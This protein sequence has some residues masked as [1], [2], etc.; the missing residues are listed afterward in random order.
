MKAIVIKKHGEISYKEVSLRAPKEGEVV[1]K[2]KASG[3]C[4]TDYKRIFEGKSYFYPIILGH[5]FSGIIYDKGSKVKNFKINDKVVVAPLI[6][7]RKCSYCREGNYSL[8]E[9]YNYIGSR[10]SG[11]YAEYVIVPQSNVLKISD[12]LDFEIAAFIE[13]TAIAIHGLL[14]VMKLGYSVLV[15]GAGTIGLISAQIAYRMGA[16]K[17]YIADIKMEPLNIAKN[18]GLD[19]VL[20]DDNDEERL[21]ELKRK[22]IDVV[23]EATGNIRGFG[24]SFK[25]VKKGGKIL[26]ISLYE[27]DIK[28][29]KKILNR[30]TRDELSLFGSWNSY[31]RPFPGKEWYMAKKFMEE[32]LLYFKPLISHRIR[33]MNAKKDLEE[34][35]YKKNKKLIKAMLL[36]D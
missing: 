12:D 21:I 19:A 34:I 8:C 29:E 24:N 28:L 14:K 17:V 32:G 22:N 4:T 11:G 23:V 16:Y 15:L 6:P 7:C 27:K 1:I 30:I 31:S 3:I 2:V 13:P 5:E 33:L 36:I 9:D 35:Y 20:L 18:I 26:S 25:V 10:T